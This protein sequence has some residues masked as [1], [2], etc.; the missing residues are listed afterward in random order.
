MSDKRFEGKIDAYAFQQSVIARLGLRALKCPHL[1]TFMTELVT[2]VAKAI[3]VEFCKVL[4][5]LP[6]GDTLVLRAGIGWRKG[7]VGKAKVSAKEHSQVGYA[8]LTDKPVVV[9]DINK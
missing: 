8:L 6:D 9:E 7:L 5:I 1:F 4:E 2:E 3:N